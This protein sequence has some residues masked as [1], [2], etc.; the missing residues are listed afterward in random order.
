M[1]KAYENMTLLSLNIC[2]FSPVTIYFMDN[3]NYFF[4]LDIMDTLQSILPK[5]LKQMNIKAV[6]TIQQN[7]SPS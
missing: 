2:V 5:S 4:K 3:N 7:K 6:T 1:Y